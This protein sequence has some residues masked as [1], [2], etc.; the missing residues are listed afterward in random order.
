MWMSNKKIQCDEDRRR[1]DGYPGF[2]QPSGIVKHTVG[3]RSDLQPN[4]L[5]QHPEPE[6]KPGGERRGGRGGE[7]G[8]ARFTHIYFSPQWERK[9]THQEVTLHSS[10]S[11]HTHYNTCKSTFGAVASFTLLH[12]ADSI[13]SFPHFLHRQHRLLPGQP[14]Q[15]SLSLLGQVSQSRPELMDHPGATLDHFLPRNRHQQGAEQPQ[16]DHGSLFGGAKHPESVRD[17][18]ELSGKHVKSYTK[19]QR[20]EAPQDVDELGMNE[21]TCLPPLGWVSNKF[22]RRLSSSNGQNESFYGVGSFDSM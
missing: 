6:R 17:R 10:L 16:P 7:W 1:C 8:S 20:L 18:G 13:I 9:Q 19:Q 15:V 4:F 5:Q 12:S 22:P 14:A 21:K 3:A 11:I 2:Q